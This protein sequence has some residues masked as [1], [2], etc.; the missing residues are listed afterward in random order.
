LTG[1]DIQAFDITGPS[2]NLSPVSN[3]N[4]LIIRR[5]SSRSPVNTPPPP[6]LYLK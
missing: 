5:F 1:V 2:F 6:P 3:N 4:L